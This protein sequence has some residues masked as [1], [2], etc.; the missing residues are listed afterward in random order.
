MS[1]EEYY[2][3]T[4]NRPLR[5]LYSTAITFLNSTHQTAMDL[6]C[7]S[8]NEV[9]DL[10]NRN[11]TVHGVDFQ[12]KSIEL[13]QKSLI[14]NKNHFYGHVTTLELW[15]EWPRVDFVFSF[16][17]LSFC[18]ASYFNSVLEK[19]IAIRRRNSLALF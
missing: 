8:G 6:G 18:K 10:L 1:W 5:T 15:K 3:K 12:P 11:F 17:A 4:K 9:L 16:H 7:G 13:I 14:E 2:E 19:T